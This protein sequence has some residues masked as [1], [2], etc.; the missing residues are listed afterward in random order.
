MTFNPDIHHRR[1]IRLREFDYTEGGAYFVTICTFQGDCLFGDIVDGKMLLNEFGIAVKKTWLGIQ[2][3]LPNVDLDE[4]VIMPNHHHG[5]LLINNATVSTNVGAKQVSSASPAFGGNPGKGEAGESLASPPPHGTQSGSLAAIV[6]NYKSV[7]ARSVNKLRNN[8][9][10]PV[11]QRNY[12]ERV[13]RSESELSKVREYIINNPMKW[14]LD[15]ENP[16]NNT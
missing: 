10:C 15:K 16:I 4:F 3:H 12:Y 14:E 7:S 9:G 6:Q 8:P 11:W 13:I 1:S 2:N 5:I